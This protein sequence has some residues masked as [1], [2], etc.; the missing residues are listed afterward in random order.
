[1]ASNVADMWLF[2]GLAGTAG[3]SIT[4]AGLGVVVTATGIIGIKPVPSRAQ[5]KNVGFLVTTNFGT[6]TTDPIVKLQRLPALGAAVDISS[7]AIGPTNSDLVRYTSSP[8]VVAAGGPG[9]V[10]PGPSIGGHTSVVTLAGLVLGA[11]VLIEQSKV[12][13]VIFEAGDGIQMNITTAAVGGAPAGKIVGF[14][15]LE[16]AGEQYTLANTFFDKG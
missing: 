7:I 8:D 4:V 14:A 1:M 3:E 11:V 9:V 16:V 2:F 12:P 5:L 15:R 6:Q 10:T 13:T